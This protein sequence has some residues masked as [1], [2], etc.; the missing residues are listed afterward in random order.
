VTTAPLIPSFGLQ[1]APLIPSFGLQ[2][3]P[4]IPLFGLQAA[5]KQHQKPRL[6]PIDQIS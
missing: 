1:A 2:A 6:P 4:L 3:A 5:P